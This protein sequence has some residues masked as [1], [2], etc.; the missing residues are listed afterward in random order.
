MLLRHPRV[1][2]Y[3]RDYSRCKFSDWCS[4]K[5]LK[6]SS[7]QVTI[8]EI[9]D[10]LENLANINREKD[11]IIINLAEKLKALEDKLLAK[12]DTLNETEVIEEIE[13]NSTFFN[14]SVGIQCEH[15]EFIA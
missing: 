4:Y 7:D 2:K 14:S 9:L 6:K 12:E 8:K 1:C 3:F 15:C 10:K 5:H 13:M 11:I